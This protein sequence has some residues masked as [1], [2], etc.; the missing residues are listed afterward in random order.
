MVLVASTVV[1]GVAVLI[2]AYQ[3]YRVL[4]R[5]AKWVNA[6]GGRF[7]KWFAAPIVAA[8][9]A[10][11]IQVLAS[12]IVLSDGADGASSSASIGAVVLLAVSFT[13]PWLAWLVFGSRAMRSLEAGVE[14]SHGRAMREA[15]DP[16]DAPAVIAPSA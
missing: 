7:R 1:A 9:L 16:T 4:A 3:P 5:C 2:A 13:L 15:Q 11:V 12:L 8:I 14:H 6:D 10:V